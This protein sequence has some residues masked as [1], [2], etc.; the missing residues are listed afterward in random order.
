MRGATGDKNVDAGIHMI[1]KAVFSFMAPARLRS[2]V[3]ADTC[4][5]SV[6]IHTVPDAILLRFSF[7]ATVIGR[8]RVY[9]ILQC[10]NPK[11]RAKNRMCLMCGPAGIAT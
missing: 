9:K 11:K 3:K 10:G 7:I 1:T 8:N 5:L 2:G 4:V 6:S